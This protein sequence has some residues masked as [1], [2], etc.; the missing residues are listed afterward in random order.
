MAKSIAQEA[1][2]AL[3]AKAIN[4]LAAQAEWLKE[5][6]GFSQEDFEAQGFHI[7]HGDDLS[8]V[9]DFRIE[10]PLGTWVSLGYSLADLGLLIRTYPNLVKGASK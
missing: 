1:K 7:C 6:F 2:E 5:R 9:G 3:E 4:H 10:L 8:L